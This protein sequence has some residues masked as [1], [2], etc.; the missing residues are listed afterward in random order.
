VSKAPVDLAADSTADR[1]IDTRPH[2]DEAEALFKEARH[3][4]RRRRAW[5]AAVALMAIALI[6]AGLLL[7]GRGSNLGSPRTT[8]PTV[9]PPAPPRP[10]PKNGAVAAPEYVPVQT[11]GLAG[12]QLAWAANGTNLQVTEN[13]GQ[14]WRS[15]TPPNLG[16]MTVSEHITA[17]DA[18]GTEELWV[19]IEDVPGL[20][21]Y[22]QSVDGSDR[23]E[24][25]DH[26]TDG[27][28]TWTLS[29][30]PPGCLQTCG[31]ISV[32]FVDAEH[33]YAEASP[34]KGDST[35]FA[36]DDGGSTWLPVASMP[37]LGSVLV[38]GPIATS[39]LLF[40]SKLDGWAVTG[41][42]FYGPQGLH[43]QAS[44]PGGTLYRTINGGFSWTKAPHLPPRLQ[45]TLPV[46]FGANQGVVVAMRNI[47]SDRGTSVYVTD[48]GGATWARHPLPTL[49]Y[50]E[51]EPGNLQ[52]R[53]AAIGP[54]SWRIDVGSALYLTDNGGR[55]W[56]TITPSPQSLPGGVSSLAFSSPTNGMAIGQPM[57]C[58]TPSALVSC[59]PTLLVTTDGGRLWRAAQF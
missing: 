53:F 11:M 25:I 2:A 38:G 5:L 56:T 20:V 43:G 48:D 14:T 42:S 57:R 22:S 30:V 45:Y 34:Q 24:G 35:L 52:T 10:Q 4:R 59:F 41:P 28:Q 44:R 32:S 9:R 19:V 21:P 6:A 12:S 37:N 33:G 40:S 55:S 7:A 3:R 36:T 17:V 46:F 54:L 8:L 39:Q 16:A 31:P 47:Q 27:G 15:V 29:A 1:D 23:G 50:A 26:S 18:V 49:P 51:F 58:S 13:G